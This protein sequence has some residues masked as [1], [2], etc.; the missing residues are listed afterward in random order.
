MSK[1]QRKINPLATQG[2][3]TLSPRPQWRQ[4]SVACTDRR[5]L[6]P[7][8]ENIMRRAVKNDCPGKASHHHKSEE[9]VIACTVESPKGKLVREYMRNQF[10]G[11]FDETFY[12]GAHPVGRFLIEKDVGL[13]RNWVC[14]KRN[15][16]ILPAGKYHTNSVGHGTDH[17]G[18]S[19]CILTLV[20]MDTYAVYTIVPGVMHGQTVDWRGCRPIR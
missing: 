12:A 8:L 9:E 1:A 17:R 7:Y 13:P 18:V 20:N 19:Y 15:P 3:D 10:G 14:K 5:K 11:S 16:K 6:S 2:R 4:H